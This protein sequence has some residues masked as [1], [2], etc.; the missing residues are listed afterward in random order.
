MQQVSSKVTYPRDPKVSSACKTLINKILLPVKVRIKISGIRTDPWFN[1][2]PGEKAGSSKE[3][4]VR[5]KPTP[6]LP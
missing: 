3:Q 2:A 1:Y 4:S 5:H 6:T